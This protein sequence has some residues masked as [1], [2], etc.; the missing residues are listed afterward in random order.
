MPDIE[1]QTV[2]AY[3]HWFAV[4]GVRHHIRAAREAESDIWT[5]VHTEFPADG[6]PA[7]KNTSASI[8]GTEVAESIR[9]I[10]ELVGYNVAH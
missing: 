6:S 5:V 2:G 4:E 8:E 7:V 9:T 1:T 3:E 10:M